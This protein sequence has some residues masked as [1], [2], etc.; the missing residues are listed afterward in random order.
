M[1]APIQRLESR[2][3]AA[4]QVPVV[5]D[6]FLGYDRKSGNTSRHYWMWPVPPLATDMPINCLLERL[7]YLGMRVSQAAPS[8]RHGLPFLKMLHAMQGVQPHQPF[9]RG[10][11]ARRLQPD[12]AQDHCRHLR[13]RL[14]PW[15]WRLQRQ[16]PD[17]SGPLR[18]LCRT[19][20]GQK[21]CGS[22]PG[23]P[24]PDPGGLRHRGTALPKQLPLWQRSMLMRVG[25]RRCW[26]LGLRLTRRC[27]RACSI[28]GLWA[29]CLIG[30][31][32]DAR[33]HSTRSHGGAA[34]G[35]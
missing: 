12:R 18:R 22:R 34:S 15:W 6:D 14:P 2:T 25:V 24:M 30:R 28:F 21:H 32:H 31:G 13:R 5:Q 17:E 35:H 19:L 10:W 23:A 20:C 11:P 8:T 3:A 26:P 1:N 16:R 27:G 7:L 29:A 9:G 4:D 33:R